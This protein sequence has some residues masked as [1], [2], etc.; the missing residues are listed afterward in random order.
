MRNTYKVLAGK[1]QEI[2]PLGRS[3]HKGNIVL[4]WVLKYGVKVQ[5]GLSCPRVGSSAGPLP[6]VINLRLA[7]KRAAW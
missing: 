7:S 4:K 1:V 5:R 6:T 3:I 2:R